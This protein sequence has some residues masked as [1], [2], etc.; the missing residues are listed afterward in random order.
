[1][2]RLFLLSII[3]HLEWKAKGCCFF[4]HFLWMT[5]TT[6]L[7]SLMCA[8][9]GKYP[10]ESDWK[11]GRVRI[12]LQRPLLLV[13]L[14]NTNNLYTSTRTLS[15]I[16]NTPTRKFYIL[17]INIHNHSFAPSLLCS[18]IGRSIC[19]GTLFHFVLKVHHRCHIFLLHNSSSIF[20]FKQQSPTANQNA[21]RQP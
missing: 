9:W 21:R 17:N 16:M 10:N 6:C 12:M 8:G 18:N 19:L 3:R 7:I 2:Q 14:E 4:Q 11:L 1:M 20:I 5:L 15:K 13:P